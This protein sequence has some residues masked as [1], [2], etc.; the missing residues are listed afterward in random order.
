MQVR[1]STTYVPEFDASADALARIRNA[2]RLPT[3]AHA[4]VEDPFL[5]EFPLRY[6]KGETP[7]PLPLV[8][9]QVEG[10]LRANGA[11]G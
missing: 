9:R 6:Y 10:L 2:R 8:L 5:R 1:Y 7:A 3:D 4:L 11:S